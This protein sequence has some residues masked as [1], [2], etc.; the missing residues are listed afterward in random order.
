MDRVS[1]ETLLDSS[2]AFAD[3]LMSPKMLE[4]KS[5]RGEPLDEVTGS[6]VEG[7]D[8]TGSSSTS[9]MVPFWNWRRTLRGK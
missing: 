6:V 9:V 3:E 2:T 4:R 8:S 1:D 7:A 5:P